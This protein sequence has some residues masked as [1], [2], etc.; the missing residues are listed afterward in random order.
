MSTTYSLCCPEMKLKVWIGQSGMGRKFYVY[1]G[2]E[3]TMDNLS[4]FL[5]K[6]KGKSLVFVDDYC[7]EQWFYDCMEFKLEEE[8]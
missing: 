8:E 3:Q 2:E 5:L 7:E 6:T 1:S 4:A